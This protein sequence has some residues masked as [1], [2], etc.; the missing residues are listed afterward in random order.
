M[1]QRLSLAARIALYRIL[2]LFALL[3]LIPHTWV[4]GEL[5]RADILKKDLRDIPAWI[6]KRLLP[7]G[8]VRIWLGATPPDNFLLCDGSA[9]SRTTYAA[10]F[11]ITGTLYGAGNGTTTFNLPNLID[12]FPLGKSSTHA[13][14]STSGAATVILSVP[15]MATHR[16]AFGDGH[17]HEVTE[18]TYS[19]DTD[20]SGTVE[21]VGPVLEINADGSAPTSEV[22]TGDLEA[23]G[24]D[25]AFDVLNPYYAVNFVIRYQ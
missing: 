20:I 19:T 2:V 25:T 13:L 21:V 23:T 4:D 22:T 24:G 8:A 17:T 14:A 18:G 11:A 16:H 12:R 6:K 1:R 3:N 15:N 10:L 9:V 7:V 5:I